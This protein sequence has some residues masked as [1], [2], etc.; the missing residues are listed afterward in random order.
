MNPIA[1]QPFAPLAEAEA[2]VG[3]HLS[4][5]LQQAG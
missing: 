2:S 3:T 5:T 4:D 1:Q